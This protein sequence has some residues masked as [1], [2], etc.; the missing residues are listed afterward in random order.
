MLAALLG[1]WEILLILAVLAPLG[2]GFIAVVVYL[3]VRAAQNPSGFIPP[4]PT[5]PSASPSQPQDL[6]QQLRMLAKLKQDGIITE[7]DFNAKKKALLG[8]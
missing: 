3:L 2:L 7:E 6:E 5:S 4:I 1:G 8:I